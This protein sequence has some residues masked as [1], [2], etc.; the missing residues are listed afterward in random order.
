M[1]ILIY[2]SSKSIFA[3]FRK[4][5][6]ITPVKKQDETPTYVPRQ[7]MSAMGTY[8]KNENNDNN[9]EYKGDYEKMLDEI[10]AKE[11]GFTRDG[12]AEDDYPLFTA[13][14][15]KAIKIT[16]KPA[17]KPRSAARTAP[18]SQKRLN[19]AIA[20]VNARKGAGQITQNEREPFSVG[21]NFTFDEAP[22]KTAGISTAGN[23][24]TGEIAELRAT[25]SP[26]VE[27]VKRYM[28]KK[29]AAGQRISQTASIPSLDRLLRDDDEPD[30]ETERYNLDDILF[31]IDRK[32]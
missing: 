20:E 24:G 11:D 15:S 3:A 23:H 13:P 17:E 30:L 25:G 28:P 1:I 19:Q 16:P 5:N 29:N 12:F 31:S 32:K 7:K 21:D 10:A 4:N 14:K 18:L 2:E 6:E 9:D 27:N 26:V 22:L 8:F